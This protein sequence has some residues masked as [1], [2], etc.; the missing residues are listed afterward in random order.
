VGGGGRGMIYQERMPIE[1]MQDNDF[2]TKNF[3]AAYVERYTFGWDDPRCIWV[4]PGP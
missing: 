1:F 3:K 4:V 2:D